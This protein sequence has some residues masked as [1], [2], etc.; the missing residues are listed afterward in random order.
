MDSSTW[1]HQCW[2]FS[3]KHIRYLF[4]DTVYLLEELPSGFLLYSLHNGLALLLKYT[5]TRVSGSEPISVK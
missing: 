5:L 4:R 1:T 3:K 2:P